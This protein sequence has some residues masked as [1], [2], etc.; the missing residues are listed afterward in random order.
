M[1]TPQHLSTGE[2]LKKMSMASG[3]AQQMKVLAIS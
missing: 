2:Q 3:M 1:K